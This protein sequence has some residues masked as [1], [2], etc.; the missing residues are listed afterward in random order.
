MKKK[1]KWAYLLLL[2]GG[3]LL[4]CLVFLPI[5]LIIIAGFTEGNNI[6]GKFTWENYIYVI[7][8]KIFLQLMRKSI[9]NGIIVTFISLVISYPTAYCIAKKVGPKV[10]SILSMLIIVPFFTS[11]LLLI[12]AM[13]VVLQSN[14]TLVRF[15]Q[16]FGFANQGIL[17][18]DS[19]VIIVL[20]YNYVPYVVLNLYSAMVKI[21]TSKLYA[22]RSMGAGPIKRFT[23]II[24]PLSIS[25]LLA[26]TQLVFLPVTGSFVQ[27]NLLGGSKGMMV[28]TLINSNFTTNYN[29]SRGSAMAIIFLM[30]M[31][32]LAYI[33]NWCIKE[34]QKKI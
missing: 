24:F 12:Y 17:Y 6:L 31:I 32:T 2:P 3:S 19:A 15:L 10:Q 4:L 16:L 9:I 22:A 1:N 18:T 28:G 29:L 26:S 5:V 27:A 25:G 8:D 34:I 20:V 21:D 33:I 7:Q 23:S 11:Q 14:G 30:I 13:M